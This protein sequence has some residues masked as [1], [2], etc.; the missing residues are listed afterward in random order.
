MRVPRA[1]WAC[2]ALPVLAVSAGAQDPNDP[3][4]EPVD[5]S[6]VISIALCSAVPPDNDAFR[7][8]GER[9]C[10]GLVPCG[11]WFW[12]DAADMPATAPDNH[13]GLTPPEV[14]SALGVWVEEQGIFVSIAATPAD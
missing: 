13:D 14:A 1:L 5:Q 4:C 2:A 7:S 10:Q 6:A 8:E 12:S 3:L 9:I 11:V